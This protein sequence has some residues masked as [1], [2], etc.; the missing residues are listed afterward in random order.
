MHE[1]VPS[2]DEVLNEVSFLECIAKSRTPMG[3]HWA[4]DREARFSP[5]DPVD[6]EVTSHALKLRHNASGS[7]ARKSLA[8]RRSRKSW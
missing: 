1:A 7:M 6:D 8:P 4:E 5:R 2:G 3:L